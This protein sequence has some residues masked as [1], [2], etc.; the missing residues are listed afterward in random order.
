LGQILAVI[1]QIASQTSRNKAGAGNGTVAA[2]FE[3]EHP[4]RAVPDLCQ[5]GSMKYRFPADKQ[6]YFTPVCS[7]DSVT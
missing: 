5:V 7:D 1:W 4:R 3:F 6:V 2:L